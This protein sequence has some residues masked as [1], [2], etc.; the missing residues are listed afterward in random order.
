VLINGDD[1]TLLLR[2]TDRFLAELAEAQ[3]D[4]QVDRYDVT[5]LEHLP[6]LRT[7]S[8]FGTR[9]CVVVRGAEGLA[10]DL[11]IEV[12]DYLVAPSPD[13]VLVLVARGT[14]RIQKIARLAKAQ[15][16]RIDVR[17]PAEWDD[18]GWDRLV[19]EEFRR[20]A[21]KADAT[22][23]AA[24]RAHAGTSPATVASQVDTVCAAHS[25]VAT[26][27]GEHVD[28]VVSGQGRASGFAVADAVAERDPLAALTAL[29]GALD[30][31]EAPLAVLGALAW[32]LRQLLLARSGASAAEANVRPE[33][34]MRTVRAEAAAFHPG[35]LAWAH[36]RLA[37]LDLELKGG[38]LDDEVAIEVGVLE[39]ATSRQVGAPFNPLAAR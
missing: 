37:A 15:G 2:E 17:A 33:S 5:E 24:V 36:D 30:A 13:A 3:P 32:R 16:R 4:L 39:I 20:L 12:E 10:S 18:R 19:G 29:R 23:I 8:L 27:T 28:A 26:L 14:G 7:T 25:G 22:A 6:E 38:E 34:R 1:D 35:E 31:G 9:S 21:R 11:K